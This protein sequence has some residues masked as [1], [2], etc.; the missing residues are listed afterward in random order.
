M[1]SRLVVATEY[2]G[3]F[4]NTSS[5]LQKQISQAE[6]TG[7]VQVSNSPSHPNTKPQL[8]LNKVLEGP[9]T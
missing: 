5:L 4:T 3:V 2:F 8:Q 6:V 1:I 7:L 9:E